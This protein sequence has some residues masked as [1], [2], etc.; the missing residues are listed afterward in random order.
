MGKG[1]QER[2]GK[3]AR[4]FVCLLSLVLTFCLGPSCLRALGMTLST[5]RS[6]KT[7]SQVSTSSFC[8]TSQSD[9]RSASTLPISSFRFLLT[10]LARLPYS[11]LPTIDLIREERWREH[12]THRL[13][14]RR[15]GSPCC[16]STGSQPRTNEREQGQRERLGG[17]I[18]RTCQEDDIVVAERV[19]EVGDGR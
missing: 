3:G 14:Q 7:Y 4:S 8:Q 1:E 18:E 16:S 2:R 12:S 19:C 11:Q 13:S 5:E 6:I 9:P 17:R 15:S 10:P